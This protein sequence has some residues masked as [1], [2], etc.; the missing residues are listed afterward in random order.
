MQIDWWTFAFQAI[1]FLI[2]V[3]LLKR[4]LFLPVKEV[5]RKREERAEHA[6]V[7]AQE[8]EKAAE[9]A[10]QGFEDDR[11][12]LADERQA[13]LKK[14]HDDL[15]AER[16]QCL[17]KAAA[18]ADQ[19]L[20]AA[21]A[22]IAQEREAVLKDIRDQ[23]ATLAVDLASTLLQKAGVDASK[24]S[25]L[26]RLERQIDALP[27]AERERF[28]KDL[29]ADGAEMTIVTTSPL[30]AEEQAEWTDRL[31]GCLGRKGKAAFV[32]EPDI[33]DGAELRLPHAVITFTWQDQ[34]AK[35]KELLLDDAAPSP[36]A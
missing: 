10:R 32:T 35:A 23:V 11:A 20:Q 14:I 22:S 36:R 33:L 2:L 24:R 29:A 12:K 5:I 31:G 28:A 15:E 27:A 4:F 9:A 6:I 7:E 16:R 30:S 34:L 13:M 3:W 1:N 8:R 17:D 21:R 19:L 26:E 25:I 18:D